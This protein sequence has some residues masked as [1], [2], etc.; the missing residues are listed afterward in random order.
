MN[1]QEKNIGGRPTEYREQYNEQARKLCLLGYTDVELADFFNV[2]EQTLNTWKQKY[3]IFLE[4]LRKGKDI[5]DA[6]VAAKLYERAIGY[7]HE[8]VKI[9]AD[10]RTGMEHIVP[11]IEHYPPEVKAAIYWLNNRQKNRFKNDPSDKDPGGPGLADE[12]RAL[13]DRLPK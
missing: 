5:A 4:S 8:A 9:F 10:P 11:Y 12:L 13:A 6:E 1:E 2:S 3:P 7:Q